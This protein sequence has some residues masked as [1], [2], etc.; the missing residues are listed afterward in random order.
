MTYIDPTVGSWNDPIVSSPFI[1]IQILHQ[2]KLYLIGFHI[3]FFQSTQFW[4][5]LFIYSMQSDFFRGRGPYIWNGGPP[6]AR[7]STAIRV[8]LKFHSGRRRFRRFGSGTFIKVDDTVKVS[9]LGIVSIGRLDAIS[10]VF[11]YI[12]MNLCGETAD[13]AAGRKSCQEGFLLIWQTT[14]SFLLTHTT[15]CLTGSP[16]FT[17]HTCQGILKKFLRLFCCPCGRWLMASVRLLRLIVSA[18]IWHVYCREICIVYVGRMSGW[19]YEHP[20]AG[21]AADGWPV[22]RQRLGLHCLLQRVP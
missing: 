18:H 13:R 15:R 19:V 6:T 21:P 14:T 17:T 7:R 16:P 3:K 1:Q 9:R 4:F 2:R 10:I 22:V 8:P 12:V 11:S 20:R 5:F